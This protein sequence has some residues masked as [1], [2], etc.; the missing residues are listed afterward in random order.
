[1]SEPRPHAPYSLAVLVLGS[2]MH[3]SDSEGYLWPLLLG[4]SLPRRTDPNELL[5]SLVKYL[6]NIGMK[7]CMFNSVSRVGRTPTREQYFSGLVY[8]TVV[9][10]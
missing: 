5:R 6:A 2:C 4:S 10:G 3:V 1:M 7:S 8:G 9:L